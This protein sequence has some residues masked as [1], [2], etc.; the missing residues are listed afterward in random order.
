MLYVALDFENGLT[1]DALVDSGA[2]VSAI[3]R[4]ELDIYKQQAPSKILKI[5]DPPIFQFQ[6]ANS[7]LEKPIATVTINFDI[8]D[9]FFAEHFVV[10]LNLTGPITGLHFM[11]HNSVVVDTTHCLI[12]FPH[13]TVQVKSASSGTSAKPQTVLIHDN[14]AVPPMTTKAI[15]AFV[16]HLSERD[17]N[18]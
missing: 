6:E 17:H 11:R 2:Y 3:A 15:T 9:R 7:Q 18:R 8:G 13:L 5:D 16:D 1:I 14:I 10:M 4:K 12:Q